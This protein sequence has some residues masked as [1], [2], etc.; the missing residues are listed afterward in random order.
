MRLTFRDRDRVRVVEVTPLADGR[1][2]V[3]VDGEV[4]ELAASRRGDR[5]ELS[6]PSGTVP[7]R[8]SRDGAWRFVTV[9]GIADV[10]LERVEGRR[11]AGGDEASPEVVS[12]MPGRVVKVLVAAGD[13]VRKGQPLVVVEAMKTELALTAPRDG[14]VARVNAVLGASCEAGRPLVELAAIEDRR[15]ESPA[16]G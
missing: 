8:V 13:D 6:A 14:R 9:A 15:P 1:H 2:R 4:L 11:A 10:R 12:P 5:L 16:P 3:S 7:V